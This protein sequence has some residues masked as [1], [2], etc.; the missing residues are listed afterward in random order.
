[1]SMQTI[2]TL[3]QIDL[4]G[5]CVEEKQSIDRNALA[6]QLSAI[7]RRMTVGEFA[8]L[9]TNEFVEMIQ[10]S[11][12]TRDQNA[13]QKTSLLFN[14]HRLATK[15]KSSK[16]S[17]Y[18]ALQ[19]DGFVNG[20]A[21]AILFKKGKVNELLYQ[22]IQLGINGVQYVNEFPPVVARRLAKSYGVDA[23]AYVLDPCAGWGG[24]MIGISTVCNNY[25]CFE[26]STMTGSG[27]HNLFDFIRIM[28][29]DFNATINKLCF[30]D[31]V[32]MD[33]FYDFAITSP[34]YY[35]TEEYSHEPTNSLNR[36]KTFDSWCDGFYIPMIEKTMNAL[37]QNKVFVLNIG[38]RS[39]PLSSVL[40][41]EFSH[42]YDIKNV[43]NYLSGNA[44]LGKDGNGETFYVIRKT[45]PK[46]GD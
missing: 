26:P 39:Y 17:I 30:E 44:G 38:D 43:G 28:N 6:E 8:R 9:I 29:S 5:N 27:L 15:T 21:R 12:L 32:L 20:L 41:R 18:D 40:L 45:Q 4:F 3:S 19:N 42:K 7:L 16:H 35:D 22:A 1:M 31:S 33:G 25:T 10:Y 2:D 36:Y 46:G 13:C 37:K 34:P 11:D 14:P 24:R 23:N